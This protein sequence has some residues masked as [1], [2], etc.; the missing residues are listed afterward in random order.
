MLVDIYTLG[1]FSLVK[2]GQPLHFNRKAKKKPLYLLK[3]II[4][5]GGRGIPK[6]MVADA[7][8]P[9]S[10]GDKAAQVL[11]TTLHRLRKLLEIPDV[12][13]LD[14]GCFSI[15]RELCAIDI[16][17][18]ERLCGAADQ[19]W[20]KKDSLPTA[21]KLAQE[22]I[23]LYKGN[24]LAEDSHVPWTLVQRE[25]IRSKYVRCVGKL[26]YY[27]EKHDDF[28][29]AVE[30]YQKSIEVNGMDEEP[31]RRLMAC[32]NRMG[33]KA[34][35]LSVYRQCR[36]ILTTVHGLNPSHDTEVIKRCIAES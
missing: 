7:L 9:D 36:S 6:E 35:A 33:R 4:A 25:K 30:C 18:F 20:M 21:K 28:E 5:L 3:A 32:Y 26:G 31:Y 22:A 11:A 15:N 8:W 16:W 17:K 19:L 24:F 34:E 12:I 2:A 10:E 13:L 27:Y 23:G 14:Q 29:S 1:R